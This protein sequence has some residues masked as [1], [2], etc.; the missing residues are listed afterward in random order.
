MTEPDDPLWRKFVAEAFR[1]QFAEIPKPQEP[2]P[3][4]EDE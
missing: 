4:G 2:E 1:K 3:E